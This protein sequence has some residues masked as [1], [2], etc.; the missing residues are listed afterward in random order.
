MYGYVLIYTY[1]H[2]WARTFS[3]GHVADISSSLRCGMGETN[4]LLTYRLEKYME[5]YCLLYIKRISAALCPRL[6]VI[7]S[8]D[9]TIHMHYSTSAY[10][11]ALIV[12]AIAEWCYHSF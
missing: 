11:H 9:H 3:A 7:S 12:F 6:L 5:Y 8:I 1:E 2:M 10:I 4:L